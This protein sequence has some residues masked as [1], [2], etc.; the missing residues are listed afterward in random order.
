MVV[1]ED[2]GKDDKSVLSKN[3]FS[4]F[5]SFFSSRS[6][7]KSKQRKS[8]A[9]RARTDNVARSDDGGKTRWTWIL[10]IFSGKKTRD[11]PNRN[12]KDYGKKSIPK[13][14]SMEEDMTNPTAELSELS[15]LSNSMT[16]TV[17]TDHGS[18]RFTGTT[19][20]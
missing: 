14:E 20:V 5:R 3:S 17:I 8:K 10:R 19:K 1:L 4:S 13:S 11:I 7:K 15:F 2:S 9:R 12:G 16:E 18:V 6:W